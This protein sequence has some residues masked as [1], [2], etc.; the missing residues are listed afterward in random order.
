M[1]VVD[2]EE[3]GSESS[4]HQGW[5]HTALP[6]EHPRPTTQTTY[7]GKHREADG[8]EVGRWVVVSEINVKLKLKGGVT[9]DR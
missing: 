7:R 9:K 3:G 6:Q 1:G 4:Q 5:S 2:V 8:W